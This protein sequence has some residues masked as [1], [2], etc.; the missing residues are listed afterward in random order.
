[1]LRD[2]IMRR[3]QI[4]TIFNYRVTTSFTYCKS[5][6]YDNAL[7][8]WFF[9]DFIATLSDMQQLY[10]LFKDICY[11]AMTSQHFIIMAIILRYK[12]PKIDG[13]VLE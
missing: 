12:N 11:R 4:A 3:F 10:E 2:K 5:Q 6:S 7:P 8:R 13:Q 1:M 9:L